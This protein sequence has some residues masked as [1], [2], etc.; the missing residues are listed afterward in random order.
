MDSEWDNVAAFEDAAPALTQR[1]QALSARHAAATIV[2]A[3]PEVAMP[4]PVLAVVKGLERDGIAYCYWKSSRRLQSVLSG[5]G[6]L[7][8]LIAASDQH[9]A[10]AIL[11]KN[12]LKR[13]P[14]VPHRDHPFAQ[15]GNRRHQTRSV[16]PAL[17]RRSCRL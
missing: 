5:D 9:C 17:N 3:S 15:F 7:D 12:D 14:S 8:L 6:Y 13:I 1:R 16:A 11:L 10:E 2:R 4:A